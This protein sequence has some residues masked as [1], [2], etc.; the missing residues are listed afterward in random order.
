[1]TFGAKRQARSDPGLGLAGTAIATTHDAMTPAAI[2]ALWDTLQP[3]T[4]QRRPT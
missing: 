2:D 1:M 3:V 4:P